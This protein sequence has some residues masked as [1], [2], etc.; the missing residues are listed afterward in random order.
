[1]VTSKPAG[2]V[3]VKVIPVNVVDVFGLVIEKLRVVVL[4]V[5]IGFAVND[6]W[7]TGGAITDIVS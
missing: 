5:K 7:I 6:F 4:P 2:K 1:M 3:S